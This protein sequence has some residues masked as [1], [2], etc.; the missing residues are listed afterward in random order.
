ME[1]QH[2]LG[3]G[4]FALSLGAIALA[5]P[6][7][8][9]EPISP[10]VAQ[11]EAA[12]ATARATAM[13][14]KVEPGHRNRIDYAKLDARLRRMVEKPTMV[15]MAVGIVENGRIT[16]LSG[17]GET[18]E[19]SGEK[20][21]SDTIFRWAS[22]SKGVASTMVAKL[23]E[24]GR[25]SF[26]QPVATLAPSLHLPGRNEQVATVGDVLSHRLGL[27]RNAF[28]NKLEEGQDVRALRGT[29]ATLNSI[30]A[31]GTC[32]SYQ[33]V[34]YDAASEISSKVTG[35]SYDELVR[36]DLF[37]PL[38]M[39]S[40]SMT[41]EGLTGA[42]SWARPHSV[43]RRILTPNDNYYRVPAAGGVNSNI[44]DMAVWMLA[45]MGQMPAVLSPKLLRTIHEPRV[46]TPG[47]RRRMRK[48]LERLGD[49]QYGYGWR[50]YDYAGHR[51]VGHRGGVDGYRSLILFDP[52]RKSG[53]VA[54][55]NSN[56][57]QPG[58][59]EFEVMDM[60]YGLE[61][62]DWME[63]DRGGSASGSSTIAS[64]ADRRRRA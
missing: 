22:V 8:D 40:A 6:F 35:L 52:E 41:L 45:Q 44:K 49:A 59:L 12:A 62:R 63:L 25:L 23:E 46:K 33:N 55:W 39:T 58:G 24:Q 61:F 56:T 60:L 19:G 50:S 29:L 9:S 47:E 31:P 57:S 53:V 21:S 10:A 30:C 2:T 20:V 14:A 4:I 11:Q 38:G 3:L 51:L 43:G 5:S 7:G 64:G 42:K 36:R 17:Y 54:L 28:D 37:A 48:F 34:A 26:H 18:A 13:L 16:F 27:Y 15:G 32:W 1:R